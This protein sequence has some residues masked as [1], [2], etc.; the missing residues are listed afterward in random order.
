MI[1][2]CRAARSR[3][4]LFGKL[5]SKCRQTCRTSAPTPATSVAI[6]SVA[7]SSRQATRTD[8]AGAHS[9]A[10]ATPVAPSARS[11]A[12]STTALSDAAT[13]IAR[14]RT[15]R[16]RKREQESTRQGGEQDGGAGEQ[17]VFGSHSSHSRM[18]V[19]T[20]LTFDLNLP[21]HIIAREQDLPGTGLLRSGEKLRSVVEN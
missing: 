19:R 15:H 2:I 6:D 11:Q 16:M 10:T 12:S 4:I 9:Q 5:R 8:S 20:A 17:H 1:G 21:H 3:G 7:T 18:I 14:G 13:P